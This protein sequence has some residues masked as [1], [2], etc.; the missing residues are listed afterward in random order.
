MIPVQLVNIMVTDDPAACVATILRSIF[1]SLSYMREDFNYLCH[2]TGRY[3]KNYRCI[4]MFPM[5]NIVR[6]GLTQWGRDKISAHYN[7]VIMSAIA[8]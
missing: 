3:D 8:S 2:V 7:D 1:K 4:F 6:K 5:T